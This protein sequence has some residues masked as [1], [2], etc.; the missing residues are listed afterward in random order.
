MREVNSHK[1]FDLN[2]DIHK[3]RLNAA[4]VPTYPLAA[5]HYL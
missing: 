3:N 2:S 5:I 4:V 1:S